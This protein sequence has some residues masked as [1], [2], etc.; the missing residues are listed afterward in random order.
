MGQRENQKGE[1]KGARENRREVKGERRG[2]KTTQSQTANSVARSLSFRSL[3]RG[4]IVENGRPYAAWKC[5]NQQS[6]MEFCEL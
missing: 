2:D 1:S 4:G 3:I 6:G 5:Q